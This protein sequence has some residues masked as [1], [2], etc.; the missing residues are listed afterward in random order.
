MA[1]SA[2]R[3][4]DLGI[5]T[6]FVG[7]S[8]RCVPRPGTENQEARI[9]DYAMAM[10]DLPPEC[11]T[12]ECL[13]L[14]STKFEFFP[15]YSALR[16]FLA[17]YAKEKARAARQVPGHDDPNLDSRDRVYVSLWYAHQAAD[18]WREKG[19]TPRGQLEVYRRYCERGYAYLIKHNDLAR[20]LAHMNGWQREDDERE[21][22]ERAIDAAAKEVGESLRSRP[23]IGYSEANQALTKAELDAAA[24]VR[25]HHMSALDLKAVRDANPLIQAARDHQKIEENRAAAQRPPPIEW[26]EDP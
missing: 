11:F 16:A 18:D 13:E 12:D 20:S 26:P 2:G 7:L 23:P 8:L 1:R 3:K 14:C 22:R 9:R 15:A 25:S 4:A 17:E 5:Q 21:A 19:M 10:A 24:V 6:W